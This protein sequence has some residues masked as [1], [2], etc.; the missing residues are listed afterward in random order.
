MSNQINFAPCPKCLGQGE[1]DKPN[2]LPK[3]RQQRAC[4]YCRGR[5]FVPDVTC[6]GCGRPAMHWDDPRVS[7]CG[8]K[9]CVEKLIEVVDPDE[10]PRKNVSDRAGFTVIDRRG[11]HS[12]PLEERARRLGM[13]VS[14]FCKYM[15]R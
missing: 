4:D 6:R 14:E 3:F 13:S 2:L 12:V 15:V 7:S 1:V 10:E 5:G 9:E 8:R 11:W